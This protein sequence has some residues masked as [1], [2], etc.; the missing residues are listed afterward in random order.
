MSSRNPK[1]IVRVKRRTFDE[2]ERLTHHINRTGG[3]L[4]RIDRSRSHLNQALDGTG[5]L[6]NDVHAGLARIAA[7]NLKNELPAL[8]KSRGKKQEAKRRAEGPKP[9]YHPRNN[10]PWT[11]ILITA[12]PEFFR[13]DG[14]GPGEWDEE[15]KN[16][17]VRRARKVLQKKFG[18]GLVRLPRR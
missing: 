8:R 5:H 17:F 11:E 2:L 16:A 6:S 10:K 7:R 9:P 18:P 14:Q 3:D 4:R 13:P 15:R 12:S 1:L